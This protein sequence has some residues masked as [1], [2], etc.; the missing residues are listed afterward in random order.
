M[1]VAGSWSFCVTC[2]EPLCLGLR[3][4]AYS[5]L[6]SGCSFFTGAFLY[7][8][9]LCNFTWTSVTLASRGGKC[10][11]RRN[12]PVTENL[13]LIWTAWH[14]LKK[15]K[16][17]GCKTWNRQ[18]FVCVCASSRIEQQPD[19]SYLY[20]KSQ[21]CWAFAGAASLQTRVLKILHSMLSGYLHGLV[22]VYTSRQFYLQVNWKHI[23]FRLLT[24]L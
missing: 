1:L 5:F 6:F 20:A 15:Y 11:I 13:D 4:L 17:L 9:R 12:F 7:H 22:D 24:H 3:G 19:S 18:V 23:N 8:K 14:T 2:N 21:Q 10:L 16:I